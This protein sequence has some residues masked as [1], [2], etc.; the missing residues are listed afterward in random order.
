[1]AEQD[2]G[3]TATAEQDFTYPIKVED[4]GPATKR[5]SIEIPQERIQSKLEEQFKELRQQAAIPGFRPGHAPQKLIEKRFSADVKEQVRR[6]LI[7]ESYEQAVEKNN[8]Q[9]IGEPTF[10]NPEGMQLPEAGALTYSFEV[11]VQPD[12]NLPELKG[13]KI[14][15]PSIAVSDE[16]IDQAM[17]NLREQQGTLVPVEDRGVEAGDQLVADIHV[18]VEGNVVGQQ[19]DATIVARPGQ[20]GGIEI[21]DL[22]K[23]LAGMKPGETRTIKTHVPDD[24][25]TEVIKGKDVEIEVALKDLKKLELAEIDQEFLESLGFENEKELREALREQ[26]EERIK[27]DVQQAMREQVYKHLLDSVNI[28]LPTRLSDRQAQRT[29]QRR[30]VDMLMRGMPQEQI[31]ANLARF[32]AGAAEEAQRELKLFFILQKIAADQNVDVEESELNGRIAMIAAQQ[33]RRPEKLKQDMA[34]DG[35]LQNMFVQMREQKAVDKILEDATFEEIDVAE[36][37]KA[38]GK[39]K[40]D[41]GAAEESNPESTE[42]KKD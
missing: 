16:H 35:T 10:A 36:A 24:N 13:I 8:L 12:I 6:S 21:E 2:T 31:Q 26:M 15:R 22:D 5:V 7:S 18:K 23:Q 37:K 27:F 39:K 4:A 34:K 40:K 1:M 38:K 20:I 30:M 28:E 11:E 33:G 3:A 14:K 17:Q 9:V 25:P 19:Q 42:E 29:V 41:E 32:Q